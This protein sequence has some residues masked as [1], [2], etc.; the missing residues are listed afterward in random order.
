MTA[1]KTFIFGTKIRLNVDRYR[2]ILNV[3]NYDI[4]LIIPFQLISTLASH[5]W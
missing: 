1:I 2:D 4:I 5:S 3:T